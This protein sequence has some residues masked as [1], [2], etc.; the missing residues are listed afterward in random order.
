MVELE[1]GE[2]EPVQLEK[3]DIYIEQIY[4]GNFKN[5]EGK[6]SVVLEVIKNDK[7]I[8]R[9]HY[10]GYKGTTKN[11]LPLLACIE[12]LKYIKQPCEIEIHIDSPYMTASIRLLDG[13]IKD[14]IEKHK[15]AD[16]WQKYIELA[17]QHLITITQEKRNQYS[18]AMKVQLGIKEILLIEDY[19]EEDK[20]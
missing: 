4:S 20:Y 1:G 19:R 5:G 7:P 3:I 10:K 2:V 16:L 6:F 15:N 8:T 18:P 13:W 14:G 11:R 12:A 17:E 9:E